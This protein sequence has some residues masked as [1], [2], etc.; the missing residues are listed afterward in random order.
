MCP[1][2]IYCMFIM[3]FNQTLF[4]CVCLDAEMEMF[5]KE[6]TFNG[7][8]SIRYKIKSRKKIR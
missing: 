2:A 8:S 3:N 6:K 1:E 5:F 4:L 7:M